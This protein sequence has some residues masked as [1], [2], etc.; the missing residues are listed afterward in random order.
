M[1]C[2]SGEE[3]AKTN[4]KLGTS[5]LD[6]ETEATK[7]KDAKKIKEKEL[8]NT[9]VKENENKTD[10][11]ANYIVKVSNFFS[12]LSDQNMAAPPWSPSRTPPGTPPKQVTSRSGK[13]RQ[14]SGENSNDDEYKQQKGINQEF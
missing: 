3:S 12:P 6:N 9:S 10:I 4:C 11:D 13:I 8:L 14:D 1:S 2:H 5:H 7:V